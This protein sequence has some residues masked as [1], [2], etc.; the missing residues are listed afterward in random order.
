M[1][2]FKFLHAA[3][4]HLDSPLLGLASKSEA[5]ARRVAEASRQAF[6]NLIELAIAEECRFV[7][8][9]G[10]VFDGDLRNLKA[11][12]FFVDRLRRLNE[13]GIKVFMVLGNHDAENRF[14]KKL[15]FSDNVHVFASKKAETIELKDIAVA[16]HGRSFPQRDVTDNLAQTYPPAVANAYNIGVLHTACVGREG[17]HAAYA[18]CSVEQLINHGYD[19][20]ALGHVHARDVLNEKTPHIVYP[21]NLQ[22]RSVRETGDKGCTLVTVEDGR[23]TGLEH[24]SLDVVRWSHLQVDVGPASGLSEVAPLLRTALSR[25][26]EVS[27]GRAVAARISLVG[28]TP[29]HPSL[30]VSH[31]ALREDIETICTTLGEEVWVEKIVV[32]TRPPSAAEAIDASIAGQISEVI[33]ATPA[34][35]LQARLEARLAEVQAKLPAGAR[36]TELLERLRADSPKRALDLA[37]AVLTDERG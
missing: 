31:A 21:G 12:L 8:F 13:A 9:A 10:D 2:S 16:L 14:V 30:L 26:I 28:E 32:A 1:T 4:L 37:I 20:W 29:I 5:F 35:A 18:P 17:P 11:G 34:E 36:A 33:R 6:D 7:I 27:D 23:L 25:A 15:Q 22:G 3:D 24:R 19:Y